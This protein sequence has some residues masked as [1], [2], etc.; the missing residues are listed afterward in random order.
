[1]SSGIAHF[2]FPPNCPTP[3][4]QKWPILVGHPSA[5]ACHI[6]LGAQF[7]SLFLSGI[8]VPISQRTR[9][10]QRANES[11]MANCYA[12]ASFIKPIKSSRMRL[13][14]LALLGLAVINAS[15]GEESYAQCTGSNKLHCCKQIQNGKPTAEETCKKYNCG[16]DIQ[17]KSGGGSWDS[18]SKPTNSWSNSWSKP[19]GGWNSKVSKVYGSLS[20]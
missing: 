8:N 6:S 4:S 12:L 11:S 16:S 2:N 17:C 13:I 9:T 7:Q 5:D 20:Q 14:F 10:T 1:L 15:E 3:K 18:W 19:S